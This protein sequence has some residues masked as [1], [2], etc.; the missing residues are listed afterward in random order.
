MDRD[1]GAAARGGQA[2]EEEKQTQAGSSL[3]GST[4]ESRASHVLKFV[5]AS[6]QIESIHELYQNN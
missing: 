1:S 3:S 5:G 2:R 6:R 4:R